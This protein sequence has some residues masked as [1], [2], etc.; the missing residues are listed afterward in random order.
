MNKNNKEIILIE[1]SPGDFIDAIINGTQLKNFDERNVLLYIYYI[2][3]VLRALDI[4]PSKWD[5]IFEGKYRNE[6]AK[7]YYDIIESNILVFVEANAYQNYF[8]KKSNNSQYEEQKQILLDFVKSNPDAIHSIIQ[9]EVLVA[10]LKL[11]QKKFNNFYKLHEASYDLYISSNKINDDLVDIFSY[12]YIERAKL[13]NNFENALRFIS[14]PSPDENVFKLIYSV[15]MVHK[16]LYHHLDEIILKGVY[17][18]KKVVAVQQLI[19][20]ETTR[21]HNSLVKSNE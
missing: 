8:A 18:G 2:Y 11:M 15:I 20:E 21:I 10:S 17:N 3:D 1:D 16:D 13:L 5:E 9:K 14:F 19:L 4:S 7:G 12:L 6:V